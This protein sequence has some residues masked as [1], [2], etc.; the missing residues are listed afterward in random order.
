MSHKPRGYVLS[1]YGTNAQPA[2][3]FY[4]S[5]SRF[6]IAMIDIWGPHGSG[7]SYTFKDAL[8]PRWT[9]VFK[10]ARADWFY[11]FLVRLANGEL[12]SIEE[13]Q[14][15]YRDLFGSDITLVDDPGHL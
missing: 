2:L 3:I 7:A 10:K 9:T 14:Q 5:D 11:P 8:N 4:P 13:I 12:V 6:P 1:E 15:K